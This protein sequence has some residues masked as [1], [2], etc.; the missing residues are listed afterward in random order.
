MRDYLRTALSEA[1][2]TADRMSELAEEQSAG[3]GDVFENAEEIVESVVVLTKNIDSQT[4]KIRKVMDYVDAM[5]D[6]VQKLEAVV[7]IK[8]LLRE[9]EI[10]ADVGSNKAVEIAA[11]TQDQRGAARDVAAAARRLLVMARELKD[12]VQRFKV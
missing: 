1:G 8:E 12:M 10:L 11:A 2:Y 4:Q 9:S 5:P 6:D 3:T 7:E